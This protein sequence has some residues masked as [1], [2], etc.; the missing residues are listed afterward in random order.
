[1]SEKNVV[2]VIPEI[3]GVVDVVE[4]AIEKITKE[5]G[6]AKEKDFAEPISQ[7]LIK[8]CQ[9]STSLCEDVCQEHK[10]W[11]RCYSYIY[12]KAR[13]QSKGNSC[14]VRDDVVFEW[15]EDYFHFDDKEAIEK[16]EKEKENRKK[17]AA[18]K[19]K[20]Q[21]ANVDEKSEKENADIKTA[22]KNDCKVDLQPKTV[23]KKPVKEI[24][25]QMDL[26]SLMG[27]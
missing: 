6:E 16:E 19:S 5:L 20:K 1:M 15:A 13:K 4:K 27:M 7:Y 3:E 9:E 22:T 24:D 8:R 10:N 18:E 25:G 2:E 17:K 23:A 26:F 12:E 11:S 21:E 14:A